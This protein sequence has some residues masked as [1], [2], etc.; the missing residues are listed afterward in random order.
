MDIFL[1]FFLFLRIMRDIMAACLYVLCF[2]VSRNHATTTTFFFCLHSSTR[3]HSLFDT[4]SSSLAEAGAP[5]IA[6]HIICVI[7]SVVAH[8]HHT[9]Q[10]GDAGTRT[11]ARQRGLTLTPQPQPLT[12]SPQ[13]NRLCTFV[14]TGRWFRMSCHDR[15]ACSGLSAT[16][17]RKEEVVE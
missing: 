1:L 16:S 12:H 14:Y 4:C 10:R 9:M 7:H 17:S 6:Y 11:R 3:T 13:H 15:I 2:S 5:L 8:A